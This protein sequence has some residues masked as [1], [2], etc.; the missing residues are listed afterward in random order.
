M[1]KYTLIFFLLFFTIGSAQ[2]INSFRR[3]YN[4]VSF[5]NMK[6]DNTWTEW[7]ESSTSVVFNHNDNGD[8]AIFYENGDIQTFRK[9]SNVETDTSSGDKYQ[10][11]DALDEKGRMCRIQL[12]DKGTFKI[13]YNNFII[14]L[15]NS[16]NY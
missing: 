3:D 6:N 14:Q 5:Y 4:L 12:F 15:E 7:E 1:K 11:F 9:I 2:D 13:I 10:I 8:I 16:N